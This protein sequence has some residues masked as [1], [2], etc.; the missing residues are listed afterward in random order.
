V[1]ER[2]KSGTH[3]TEH[4]GAQQE[5]F[6]RQLPILVPIGGRIMPSVP[7]EQL[8]LDQRFLHELRK[9]LAPKNDVLGNLRIQRNLIIYLGKV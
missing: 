2:G 7:W 1:R 9:Q 5:E 6:A 4:P 3:N 8:F